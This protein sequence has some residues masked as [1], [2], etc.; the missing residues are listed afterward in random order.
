VLQA[1]SHAHAVYAQAVNDSTSA[2]AA[3]NRVIAVVVLAAVVTVAHG[4]RGQ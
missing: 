1:L 2:M 3:G 4:F